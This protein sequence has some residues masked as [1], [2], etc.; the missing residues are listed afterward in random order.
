M[1]LRYFQL[2]EFDSPDLEGSGIN[3]NSA[4]LKNLDV[5]RHRCGF[6][7]HI[8][9]GYRTKDYNIIVKGALDSSHMRGVAADIRCRGNHERFIILR[10]AIRLGFNRIGV[11]N[12]H[13]HVD[14]DDT[15]VGNVIWTGVSR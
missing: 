13:I 5:L 10:E 2:S 7:L 3:M 4:F 1:E 11:Y 6:P 8:I 15:L 14:I 9:S 12:N